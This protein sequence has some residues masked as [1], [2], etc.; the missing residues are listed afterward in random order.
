MIRFHYVPALAL[1]SLSACLGDTKSG[2][3]DAVYFEDATVTCDPSASVWDDLFLFE[4]WTGG[5]AVSVEVE[6]KDGSS[7]LGTLP[8][9]EDE[10]GYWYTEA[11]GDDLDADCDSF[12][13]M[14]FL[15]SARGSDGSEA[16]AEAAG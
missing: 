7:S 12:Y 2:G 1:L 11:W 16:S 6:I 4:A 15:Y 9:A 10:T 14:R 13:S 5:D 8:L 3:E